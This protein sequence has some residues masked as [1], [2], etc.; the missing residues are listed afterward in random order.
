MW[1][2]DDID[3]DIS[4]KTPQAVGYVCGDRA[5]SLVIKKFERV[6]PALNFAREERSVDPLDP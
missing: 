4:S 5:Y 2:Q 6:F 1:E 3:D